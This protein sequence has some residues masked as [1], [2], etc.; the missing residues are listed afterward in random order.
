MKSLSA[1]A[2]L[3]A[4]ILSVPALAEGDAAAGEQK[5]TACIACH[6]DQTFP[7]MFYTLQLGGRNAD[8]LAIKTNKYRTGKLFQPVMNLFTMGLSEKDVADIAAYYQSLG[9]PALTSP[10]F[11]IKGDDDVDAPSV[12]GGGNPATALATA[13]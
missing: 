12:S 11:K 2:L 4:L 13:K 9:K 6:G 8:K 3:P 1:L 7:G 10:L 5:A